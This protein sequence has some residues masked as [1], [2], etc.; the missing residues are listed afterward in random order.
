[1]WWRAGQGGN[2]GL[3]LWD[4]IGP[5]PYSDKNLPVKKKVWNFDLATIYNHAL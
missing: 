1:M 5:S 3:G 2:S 4:V